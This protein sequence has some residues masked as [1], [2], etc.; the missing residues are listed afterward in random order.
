M[1]QFGVAFGGGR[2]NE[3]RSEY[4]GHQ[5]SA[6]DRHMMQILRIVHRKQPDLRTTIEFGSCFD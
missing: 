5:P 6:V 1:I 3:I 2:I 4:K